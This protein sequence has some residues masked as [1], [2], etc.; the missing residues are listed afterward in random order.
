MAV[1]RTE[2][3]YRVL[4]ED[5]V[6]VTL[7][8]GTRIAATVWRPDTAERVPV[9]VEMIPYRRRDGT[10]FRDFEIH[11]YLAGFGVASIRF[12]LRGSGDSDGLLTDEY[13]PLEQSDACE[14]I[15]WAAAQSWSNGNVGMQGISWGGFNSLQVAAHRPPALK[16]II[17]LCA[18]DDR[19]ADD[20]HYMGGA[21]ITEQEMWSNFMLAKNA[22][23]PDPRIVGARWREM[24]E[25]RREANRSL[26]EVWLGH[27]RRDA[28]FKQGSVIENYSRI[29]CAVLA[30]AGW[31]DSYSNFVPRL[32]AG[33]K[34]PRLG[35]QGPWTH[36]FPNRGAPGPNIGYLQECLRWWKHWLSGEPTGI[37][38]EPMYRVWIGAKERPKPYYF[39]DHKGSWAAESSWPSPRIKNEVFYLNAGLDRAPMPGPVRIVRSPA[40]AGTDC[41]RHGGYGGTV[42][43]M[44]VD[45]RREDGQGLCFDTAILEDDLVLLGAPVLDIEV[46]VDQPQANL[47]ARLCDV[48]PDGTSAQMTYG[49]LN[50]SHRNSHE[51]PEACPVGVPFK[52]RLQLND[53][54]R[55]IPKG[56]RIRVGLATQHWPIVW[57]QAKLVNL[58][59]APGAGT[60][61]LPVRPPSELD[62]QVRFEPPEVSAPVPSTEL[63]ADTNSRIHQDDVGTGL[64]TITLTTDGG[65]T[66]ID[67]RGIEVTSKTVDRFEIRSDDP[68]SARLVSIY[69]WGIKS[70]AADTEA[71]SCTELTADE[72]HFTLTWRVDCYEA[73]K[74]VHSA[75]R[76]KRIKRD[77]C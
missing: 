47:I 25:A 73:G 5:P 62:A 29:T 18:S 48:Y 63:V 75:G 51:F 53:F 21:L 7:A 42:P 28:Y 60:L 34:G 3:P 56:H 77:F 20:I 54:G 43:D 59:V 26:S 66:R 72:T 17:T 44:P 46:T 33:L 65:R 24:W 64:R 71:R 39:P 41:G 11:P 68:L 45:Q 14:L 70:G 57:P 32:L 36:A 35:I 58:S 27:Q 2:Y 10:V 9:V 40:T 67:D 76:T 37:M 6:F 49:V 74:V 19:Y 50:L 23:P 1:V 12:D 4:T 52:V 55:M 13:L 31:E 16:A 22:M 38:D 69:D 8:D 15:A 61:T 30:I